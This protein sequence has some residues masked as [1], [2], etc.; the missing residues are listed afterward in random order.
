MS[1]EEESN[2]LIQRTKVIDDPENF[3]CSNEKM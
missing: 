3:L 1:L 2:P